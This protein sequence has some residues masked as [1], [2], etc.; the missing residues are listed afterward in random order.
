[1]SLREARQEAYDVV[2]VGSGLGGLSA[3]ALLAHA[4]KRVL[5]VE[6]HDRPGGFT[7]C[8][9][10]KQYRFDSAVHLLPGCD[11]LDFGEGALAHDVLRILGVR[12]RV[13]FIPSPTFYTAMFPDMKLHAPTGLPGFL[14]AHAARFPAEEKALRRLMR[15]FAKLAREFKRQP[16]DPPPG[17]VDTRFFP[18]LHQ[19][20]DAT[21]AQV[22]A[23]HIGDERL[24]AVVAA[25]WPFLG[26]PPS[27][28]SAI[29]FAGLLMSYV[30]TGSFYCKGTFQKLADAFVEALR[31]NGGEL[32]LLTPVRRIMVEDGTAAG[33]VLE[34]GQRIRAPVVISN[35]DARQTFDELVGPEY[36]PRAFVEA[37]RSMRP[38]L[39]AF[40]LY[41]ATSLDMRQFG[42]HEMFVYDTW[43][44]E[45]CYRRLQQ[46][47][48]AALMVAIPSLSDPD[49][50]PP[51]E[52][53][54]SVTSLAPYEATASWRQD[55]S[56]YAELVLD[57]MDASFPGFRSRITF[58]EGATPRT[59]E[60]FT[61]NLAGSIYGW[62]ASPEHTGPRR[63]GHRTPISGLYLSG[64]WT[65]PGGGVL[66]VIASG[67]ETVQIVLGHADFPSCLKALEEARA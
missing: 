42:E 10:R 3:A 16:A 33:I 61:L 39:S 9:Q 30:H 40:V 35:A 59:V 23:E 24:K 13:T 1:L 8:F 53:I 37:L 31:N 34:N 60:R 17:G 19:H 44:H 18:T 20:R 15:L 11:P 65:Q 14:E 43:D 63:L 64:H 29:R 12:D 4:G 22:M 2:V 66:S 56:R 26:L 57:L 51:G 32:L 50:A 52:H 54:V 7:H 21:L 62:E 55:K 25:A 28:L 6:R 49:L 27:R 48:P 58:V 47:K 41:T 45:E 5:V 67:V 36:L 38:A 46:G